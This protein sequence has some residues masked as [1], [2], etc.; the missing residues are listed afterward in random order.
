MNIRLFTLC[1]GAYNYNG[2]L[3]V[4]GTV[5]NIKVQTTPISVSIGIAIKISFPPS[6]Y[7]IKNLSIRILDVDNNS[8]MPDMSLPST[9]A[10]GQNGEEA[11][12]VIAGNLQG[13]SFQHEGDYHARLIVN[14]VFYDLPFR[15]T[16]V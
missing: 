3:T 2:K 12:I 11:R 8:I 1:D 9:E 6:E 13:L 4:V 10:R 14:D 5:D 16:T 15:V 7:G